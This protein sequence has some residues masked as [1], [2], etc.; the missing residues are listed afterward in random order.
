MALLPDVTLK[1]E[2]SYFQDR[3]STPN[4]QHLDQGHR[5]ESKIAPLGKSASAPAGYFFIFR[6]GPLLAKHKLPYE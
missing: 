6:F 1:V 5:L 4:T 3:N 2:S